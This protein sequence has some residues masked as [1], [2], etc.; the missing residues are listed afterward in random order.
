M[1]ALL[2]TCLLFFDVWL[3]ELVRSFHTSPDL[4]T[5]WGC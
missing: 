5:A 2:P 4:T 3:R 1:T